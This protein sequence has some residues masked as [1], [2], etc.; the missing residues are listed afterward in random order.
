MQ[1]LYPFQTSRRC[2][3]SFEK[4]GECRTPCVLFVWPEAQ[5]VRGGY[6][7]A[8]ARQPM[9]RF[10]PSRTASS[11]SR[12]SVLPA[13][14][15]ARPAR[16]E[17]MYLVSGSGSGKPSIAPSVTRARGIFMSPCSIS[18]ITS[19][20]LAARAIVP[21]GGMPRF[22][23]P[24]ALRILMTCGVQLM[25]FISFSLCK[26]HGLSRTKYADGPFFKNHSFAILVFYRILE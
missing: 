20:L 2:A 21:D 7:S 23:E 13:T 5:P 17:T 9:M 4:G 16:A 26:D 6:G 11:T 10:S 24:S 18:S 15:A 25:S 3:A 22:T 14:L 8:N 19:R 12:T 1:T